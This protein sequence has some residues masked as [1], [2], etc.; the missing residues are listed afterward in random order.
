MSYQKQHELG[1]IGLALL[2]TWLVGDK[3]IEKK[4]FKEAIELTNSIKNAQ[5]K[6][7]NSFDLRKG[8]QS[9][10]ITYDRI[11]NLLT[12]IEEP[13]VKS[14]LQKFPP[15]GLALDA[16]CGTGR[17]S[18]FLHALGYSVTGVDLSKDMLRMARAGAAQINFLEGN[19]ESLPIGNN[20]MDL[21]ISA[22]TLTHLPDIRVAISELARTV[23]IGGHMIISDI[24]PWLIVLGGQADF[25]DKDGKYGY[26][27]NYVH[28]HSSYIQAFK[29]NGLK[30]VQCV[31]P[32]LE[33]KHLKLANEGFD[34]SV[35]TISAALQGLPIALIWV[36]EKE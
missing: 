5:F 32:V 26:V 16:G 29:E 36:L 15:P 20:S 3:A 6:K 33:A 13:I 17:Y 23:K 2:R 4:L 12:K 14:I 8:Y 10:A 7:V 9:W 35:T 22:L 27:R 30:I 31:E 25:Y 24:H 19:L 1:L 11:P 28:W 21:T 18:K 34:L